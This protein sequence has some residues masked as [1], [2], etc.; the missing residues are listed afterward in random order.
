MLAHNRAIWKKLENVEPN[1]CIHG[2]IRHHFTV[3]RWIFFTFYSSCS[4]SCRI[5][6]EVILHCHPYHFMLGH[7][8]EMKSSRI[9]LVHCNCLRAVHLTTTRCHG[10]YFC[11]NS[12]PAALLQWWL[13]P[14]PTESVCFSQSEWMIYRLSMPFLSTRTYEIWG[15]KADVQMCVL[16]VWVA[17][18][19]WS[20][21]FKKYTLALRWCLPVMLSCYPSCFLLTNRL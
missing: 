16:R 13:H 11:N 9:A 20:L 8:N 1:P 17:V 4:I 2:E 19:H 10:V 21:P 18:Y 15:E 3:L 14:L 7:R 12:Q 6:C 5:L